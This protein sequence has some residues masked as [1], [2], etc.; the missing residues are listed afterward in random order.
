MSMFVVAFIAATV[1][2]MASEALFVVYLLQ[3]NSL[4][5][6]LLVAA[7]LGNSLGSI[8]M[9]ELAQVAN[10]WLA[11]KSAAIEQRLERWQHRLRRFGTALLFFA[12]L[13]VV[14]DALPIAAGLL[15]LPRFAVYFWISIGKFARYAFIC[16]V[17]LLN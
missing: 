4:W 11:K 10:G 1:W 12:W 5:T 15:K 17:T 2:P 6:W 3:E 13:P 8:A 7:T 9:F 16:W 14:G